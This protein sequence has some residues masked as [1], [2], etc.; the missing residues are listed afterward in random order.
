MTRAMAGDAGAVGR[1]KC[2]RSRADAA[3]AIGAQTRE[4]KMGKDQGRAS[5]GNCWQRRLEEILKI[6]GGWRPVF[7]LSSVAGGSFG[8]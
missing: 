8:A 2:R 4:V 1:R 5:R 3:D 6:L 7:A